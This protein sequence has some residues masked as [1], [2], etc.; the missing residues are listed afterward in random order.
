[1]NRSPRTLLALLAAFLFA[2]P[3]SNAGTGY[4]PSPKEV[5]DFPDP[6]EIDVSFILPGWL[7]GI[8]GG[9]GVW[10]FRSEVD[11]GIDD[12]LRNLDMIAAGTI[13]V[14]RDRFGFILDGMYLKASVGGDPPGPV[15]SNV[16][17]SVEQ[18]LAEGVVTYRI[19]E[20]DRAWLELLAGARYNHLEAGLAFTTILGPGRTVS[21]EDLKA[22][23]D[24]F[25]GF[26]GQYRLCDDWYLVGRGDIGG[27]DVSSEL[28]YNLYGAIGHEFSERMSMELGYRYL[29][30]DY[31]SG[32]FVYDMVTEG[33]FAG[34]R[35][36]F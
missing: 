16:S 28:T 32:G 18:V 6:S 15:F 34:V 5:A 1:M 14:R 22:W 8:E 21:V 10:R 4:L 2:V 23:V 35:I 33:I 30:V 25:V 9:I 7:A 26:R 12:I 24:P 17:V 11:A 13:E 36:D 27:F 3:P 29:Y 19:F 31:T 20:S